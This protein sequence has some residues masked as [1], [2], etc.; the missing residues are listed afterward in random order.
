[1]KATTKNLKV[2]PLHLI[3][4]KVKVLMTISVIIGALLLSDALLLGVLFLITLIYALYMPRKKILLISYIFMTLVM[5]L[6]LCFVYGA[7]YFYPKAREYIEL[8]NLLA[9]FLRSGAAMNMVLA[10]TFTIKIQDM[11]KTLKGFKLP[12]VIYLP[13]AVMIRFIPSF[14]DDIRQIIE[15]MKISGFEFSIKSVFTNPSLMIRS[16]FLPLVYMSL[17]TADDLG[18]SAELKGV[19]IGSS[20]KFKG[21]KLT[22]ND[23]LLLSFTLFLLISLIVIQFLFGGKFLAGVH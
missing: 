2:S 9:P 17:R 21:Q 11:L 16:C 14:T 23:Y 19:G 4:I 18:I 20:T 22:R 6:S 15:T 12:Y 10:M 13:A 8:G 3:D 1:M 5:G 7:G